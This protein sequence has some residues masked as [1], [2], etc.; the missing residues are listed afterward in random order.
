MTEMEKANGAMVVGKEKHLF[1]VCVSVN[2]NNH[3]G[4]KYGISLKSR[5][6]SLI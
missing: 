4:Y 1:T 6:K 5:N 3:Y 2:W